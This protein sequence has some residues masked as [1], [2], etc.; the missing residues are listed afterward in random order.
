MENK[1]YKKE[2]DI[3]LTKE[4]YL[5]MLE[6]SI[7]QNEHPVAIRLPGGEMISDG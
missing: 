4:E 1:R 7:E 6:W 5:A 3:H 2:Q